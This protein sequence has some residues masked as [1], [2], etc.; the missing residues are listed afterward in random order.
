MGKM[1]RTCFLLSAL[2]LSGST[3]ATP[4]LQFLEITPTAESIDYVTHKKEFQL[5]ELLTEQRHSATMNLSQ[6]IQENTLAGIEALLK[7]DEDISA[8]LT[9]LSR[10][11][12]VL[13]KAAN[14]VEQAILQKKKIYI[15]G[16]GATGQLAKQLESSFW[17]PFWKKLSEQSSK[18]KKNF[19]QIEEGL[20]GEMSG[21]DRALISSLEGFEDLQLIGQ[22]QLE[23]HNIQKG[24]VVFNL[25]ESGETP[26]VIGAT[27]AALKLYGED[28]K[29][30]S[31]HLYFMYNNPDD[32]LLPLARS[33]FVLQNEAITKLRL[34]TGPQAIAG[35]TSMQAATCELFVMGIILEQAIHQ[36]LK[37]HCS[38]KELKVLGFD[39]K[40]NMKERLLSF[41][42]I[43]KAV[44]KIAPDIAKL[45][46]LEASTYVNKRFATYFA[47]ESFLTVLA[48]STERAPTFRLAPLD[49]LKEAER[50]SWIQVWNPS[51]DL[52]SA[53]QHLL[54]RPF[55]GL[56]EHR[57]KV[58]FNFLIADPYLKKL[59]LDSLQQ[60]GNDQQALYDFSFS[61]SNI[62]RRGPSEG[63]LGVMSLLEDEVVQLEDALFSQWMETFTKNR[64]KIGLILVTPSPIEEDQADVVIRLPISGERDPLKLRQL[65]GLKMLLNAHST[66]VMAKL[67]RVV[68][69]SMTHVHPGNL[70]LIGRATF[71]IM[72]YVNE[73][74]HA[75]EKISYSEANAIL[76]AALE[77]AKVHQK[78]GYHPE[79]GV[80]II[81]ILE[82]FRRN[83]ATSWE[84]AEEVLQ[85]IGLEAYLHNLAYFTTE[86]DKASEEFVETAT[87]KEAD[88]SDTDWD[89]TDL[90]NL[91][92]FDL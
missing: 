62:D 37:Q 11:T 64:A 63:D 67:G 41:I 81:R 45:T 79:V 15:Y 52:D 26:S 72:S 8:T 46:D 39:S 30:A 40:M 53:W 22:L 10:Q 24:D 66:G 38:A 48:D 5:Q 6:T 90:S 32:V 78:V 73:A 70:K 47:D 7:V 17:R 82:A 76:F 77:Q 83:S 33:R 50:K 19:P 28:T 57:Y 80:S 68:G 21:G 25:T 31:T 36:V 44:Q 18:I 1:N 91:Y 43:Q 60:A 71:L 4:L 75:A 54:G 35:S 13:E 3:F 51:M 89:D 65:V 56:A 55:R 74:L 92:D 86:F 88:H 16:S 42:P 85:Q 61:L 12:A 87:P 9:A 69:N 23:E 34:P 49:S 58:P 27:L 29:E 2:C 59:A 84:E 14:A 20:I